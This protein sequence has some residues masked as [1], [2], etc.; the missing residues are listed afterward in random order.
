MRNRPP[1][2]RHHDLR[3]IRRHAV[4]QNR[5]LRMPARVLAEERGV[6]IVGTTPLLGFKSEPV[7]TNRR[8]AENFL[9]NGPVRRDRISWL[10]PESSRASAARVAIV[11]DADLRKLADSRCRPT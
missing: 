7:P 1:N 9:G 8:H 11:V 3:L 2:L 10:Q 5:R 4:Y 6:E